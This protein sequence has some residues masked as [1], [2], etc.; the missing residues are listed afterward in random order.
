MK[1][2]LIVTGLLL[3]CLLTACA[4][5]SDPV[6][7]DD[8]KE[9]TASTTTGNTDHQIPIIIPPHFDST[10]QGGIGTVTDRYDYTEGEHTI[11][12][13]TL[14]L[15]VAHIEGNDPLQQTVSNRLNAVQDEL[16]QEIDRLYQQC[17][18]D[19]RAGREVLTTPSV[20]VRFELHYFTADALSM[21]YILSQTTADAMVHEHRYHSNL[22][23]QVGSEI[24]LTALL[25]EGK[26]DGLLTLM[27]AKLTESAP[28]GLYAEAAGQMQAM[29]DGSWYITDGNL[30]V[31][32]EAGTVAPV[33][34]GDILL[35]LS[36]PQ[37]AD[38]LSDY[39]KALLK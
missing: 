34:S 7:T 32:L 39:G 8:P 6:I 24:R 20:Q 22:D 5:E 3:C 15:P 21:T 38:L 30:A 26:L 28:Q 2:K 16:K 17:L 36:A 25:S 31:L 18:A 1:R 14:N 33:S 4:P 35:T 27:Q 29:L 11:L 13:V 10:V 12:S 19:Y 9:T 37:L 23:L